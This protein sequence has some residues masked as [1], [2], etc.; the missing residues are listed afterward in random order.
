M[1]VKRTSGPCAN[2]ESD[3]ENPTGTTGNW[4]TSGD[5]GDTGEL[6]ECGRTCGPDD[7]T[8]CS[9][10]YEVAVTGASGAI[11]LC[12]DLRPMALDVDW[13]YRDVSETTS[14]SDCTAGSGRFFLLPFAIG[15]RD[16]D[17]LHHTTFLP[18][19]TSGDGVMT[20]RSW[21][22]Q[23]VAV[24]NPGSYTLRVLKA[25]ESFSFNGSDGLEDASS[26]SLAITGT[27]N[28]SNG[29]VRGNPRFVV[30]EVDPDD[31]AGFEVDMT[32]NCSAGAND[33]SRPL[34]YQLSLDT[35]GC[36][37]PQ[38]FTFRPVFNQQPNRIEFEQ[39]GTPGLMIAQPAPALPGGGHSFHFEAGDFVLDGVV[40]STNSTTAV[41]DL[42]S[43]SWDGTQICTPD[44][45]TFGVE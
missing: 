9:G 22:T 21:V 1:Q 33:I 42:T 16:H 45:Y 31:E 35:I 27:H 8:A 41:V 32:W 12:S 20:S 15:D 26:K 10:N 39:Y 24:S 28:L 18:V 34:G 44:E 40:V 7:A 19:Q 17:G 30:E 11:S 23:V 13:T 2:A 29:A 6:T 43:I 25:G 14:T 38:K 3:V 37:M 5:T 36:D 4:V